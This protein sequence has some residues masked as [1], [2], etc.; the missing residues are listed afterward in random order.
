MENRET[1]AGQA[2]SKPAKRMSLDQLLESGKAQVADLVE[3]QLRVGASPFGKGTRF[4]SRDGNF[5]V[6]AEDENGDRYVIETKL[7]PRYQDMYQQIYADLRREEDALR[8]QGSDKKVIIIVCRNAPSEL[9]VKAAKENP[10]I[11]I[12]RF[13]LEYDLMKL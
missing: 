13:F 2:A 4:L 3:A 12:F 6:R 10:D 5:C 8:E 1:A 7:R 9:V 11:R